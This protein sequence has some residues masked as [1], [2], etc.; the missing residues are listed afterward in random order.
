MII[1]VEVILGV[2]LG[3]TLS[4]WFSAATVAGEKIAAS[5]G[6]GFSQMVDPETGGQTPVVSII[7]DLLLIT[8]FLSLN[9]HLIAIDFLST[10]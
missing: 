6:L 8:I 2:S 10:A 7:L 4:I 9:G 3:L 1:I 5:T